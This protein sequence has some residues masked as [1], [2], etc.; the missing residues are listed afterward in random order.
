MKTRIIGLFFGVL[1]ATAP[2]LFALPGDIDSTFNANVSNGSVY[3][4]AAQT[5]G[6]IVI[7]GD[8]T[9]V[10]VQTRNRVARLNAD[11][12]LDTGFNPNANALV[13]CVAIQPDGKIVIG[14]QF[15]Q[16]GGLTRGNI[17]RLNADGTV[18]GTG[19]FNPG[20]GAGAEV[21]NVLIQPDGKI[22]ITG[23]FTTVNSL[24]RSSIA[25]LNA[26]GTVEDTGTFNIGTGANN[27]IYGSALQAD[28]KILI[29]GH[30][31]TF[32]G[33]TRTRIARLNS[34]GTLE[35]TGTFNPGT[36][37]NSPAYAIAQQPDGKI[38][39]GG[40]FTTVNGAAISR[41]VRLNADGTTA[42]AITGSPATVRCLALQTDGKLLVG[43]DFNALNGQA[44][45]RIA[46]LNADGTLEATGTFSTGAGA[47]NVVRGL[48]LLPDGK[49]IVSGGYTTFAG[50][51]TRPRITRLAND[52]A[53][54]TLTIPTVSLAQWT[55][56]GAGPEIIRATFELS[57]DGGTNWSALGT[58]IGT[59]TANGWDMTGLSLS[60]GGL[61][62]ARGR[63][64]GGNQTGS[65]SF[66]ETVQ[67]FNTSGPEIGLEQ[68]VNT[69]LTDGSST[70]SFGTGMTATT[71]AAK[72]FTIRNLGFVALTGVSVTRDG[73]ASSE[74]TIDTTG[75]S[76]TVAVGASTTFSVT[77]TP[78]VIGARTAMLH[79]ASDDGDENPFDIAL[80]GNGM[81]A[82]QIAQQAYA[83]ASNTGTGDV[84]GV[85]VAISGDTVV[86]G[87][88]SE[89]SSTTGIN[90]TPNESAADSG[91]VY[92]F[93]RSGSTW[94][95]QAYLKAS[96]TGAG[97]QFGVAVAIAGDTLVVGAL[98]EDGSST[99][100]NGASNEGAADSGAAYVFVRSGTT[101]TQQAY[102]KAS[103]TG[104][105]DR[106]G[107]AV[108]ISGD[109][110]VVGAYL[111]DSSATGINGNQGDNSVADCGAAYVFTR[112]GITW[113]QQAYLKGSSA[114]ISDQFGISVGISGDTVVVGDYGDDSNATGINGNAADNSSMDSGA[115][116]VFVRSG[117]TWTQQA[118]L[119]ASNTRAGDLFGYFSAIDGNT[120]V[121]SSIREDSAATGING[122]QSDSNAADAG[123][124]YV[125]TR[126]G[127]TW[128][129]QAYLKASNTGAGDNFG[130]SVAISGDTI[131]IGANLED[132]AASGVYG[133]ESD[134]SATD[135]GAAYVFVRA[136]STWL[137]QG[138]LKPSN[139][140]AGDGFGYY[141]ALAGGT[142]VV[143]AL[144]ED[145]NATGI[146]GTQTDNSLA[147][148]GAAYIF[149]GLGPADITVEQPVGTVL[150]DAV[151]S[152]AFG[153]VS[154]PTTSAAKTFT[155]TNAGIGPMLGISVLKDGTHAAEFSLNTTGMTTSLP[156]GASTTFAVNFAP[157]AAG[158]RTAALHIYCN[159]GDESPFDIALTGTGVAAPEIVVEQPVG[160]SLVDGSASIN[161]NSVALTYSST[162]KTFS[163]SNTGNMALDVTGITVAGS[164]PGDFAV[165]SFTAGSVV[166][167]ASMTFTVTFTPTAI[168]SR[169]AVVSIASDDADEGSFD[170]NV[171][172]SGVAVAGPEIA[173]EQP[174]GT[175]LPLN[176]TSWGYNA[177]SLTTLPPGLVGQVAAISG[178]HEHNV[179]LKI[180]GTVA[181]WGD[182]FYGQCNVPAGLSNVQAVAGGGYHSLALKNDGTVVAWGYGDLGQ[183]SVPGGLTNVKA[184]AG[185]NFHSLA[186]KTDGTV[187]AWGLNQYG[188]IDV[189]V[190]LNGVKAIDGG[191]YH[192]LALKTDGTVVAWGYHV[193]TQPDVP[194]GLSGVTAISAGVAFNYAL[195]NDGTLIGWGDNSWGQLDAPVGL[196]NVK[197]VV[198]GAL[199]SAVLNTDGTVLAWGYND[200]GQTNVP[201]GLAG[202]QTF[203]A[204]GH[205]LVTLSHNIGFGNV[206]ISTPSA[207]KVFTIRNTGT[208][209]LNISGV[210]VSGGSASDFSVN[211][212]GMSASVPA[213][214]STTFSVVFTPGAA[215]P[216][217]TSLRVLSDDADEGILNLGLSGNG[218]TTNANLSNLTLSQGT[219]SPL[220]A[221]GTTSYTAGVFNYVGSITVTPTVADAGATVT[222]NGNAVASGNTSGPINLVEGNN[223]INVVVTASDGSTTKTYTTTVTRYA[224]GNPNLVSITMS[225]G[226]YAPIFW[227]D[228]LNY[229]ALVPNTTTSLTVT[230]S[231]ADPSSAITVNG[232]S[233]DTNTP[234]QAI[235]LTVGTTAIAIQ[236]NAVGGATKTFT[237]YVTRAAA[238]GA[239]G[240]GSLDSSF[241]LN[242]NGAVLRSSTL[243][244]DGK[245]IVCGLFSSLGGQPRNSIARLNPD[246]SL[247]STA[248]FNPGTGPNNV[249]ISAT[250]QDD[251]KIIVA[252]YFTFWNNL[253]RNYIAR[254][255]PDG[256]L[257]STATFNTG[258][259][260]NGHVYGSWVQPDGK[261]LVWG[262]F[263]TFNGQSRKG[264]ARL[265]SDGSLE[266]TSTFNIGTGANQEIIGAALQPDGK[267]L[268][269]GLF[270]QFNGQ[271]RTHIA[272]L[273]SNGSLESLA[274]FNP[275]TGLNGFAPYGSRLFSIVP[276]PDGKILLS[277]EF[278]LADGQPRSQIAR[279]NANG[280]LDS[281][282]DP[283]TGAEG[284]EVRSMALQADGKVLIG[285]AFH[286]VN[287]EF[288]NGVARLLANGAVEGTATFNLGAGPSSPGTLVHAIA[289]QTDGRLWMIGGFTDVNGTPRLSIA[290]LLNGPATQVVNVTSSARAE[291]LRGGT[292]P[293]VS[294]VTFEK[295]MDGG[296]T[297]LMLGTG[298]RIAGGWEITG[299]SLPANGYSVRARGRVSS[300][301]LNGSS[302]LVESIVIVPTLVTDFR[303]TYFNTTSNTGIAANT[304]DPDND[305]L[306]NIVEYAFG[307][308]PVQPGASSQLP[309]PV[310]NGDNFGFSFVQPPNVAGIVYGA[311][312]S[313]NMVDWFPVPAQ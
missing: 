196:N 86:V 143:G 162:P 99:G 48:T 246:G 212:S 26:N 198:T 22:I 169:N 219:L 72:V 253:A 60:G 94:T 245:I 42:T 125:Y 102:L 194:V 68:P 44:R 248:T 236:V 173:I 231:A 9:T 58:G 188:Q 164:H 106:F 56:T 202:V 151:G 65:S 269:G 271:P 297:W 190:G 21:D 266:S 178:G 230:P 53:A 158:V 160:T 310:Q 71:S 155:I 49:I 23:F 274:T 240:P 242:A 108:T 195:K 293:E 30:F 239:P 285:G 57:T 79:I 156:P 280:S 142:A 87:A 227:Y 134:N 8:F 85:S 32:N 283:G 268:V 262:P 52:S 208:T 144:N 36:G 6:R 91:A 215:G 152:I 294:Q 24:S 37:L 255:N 304:A 101:W 290:R 29:S 288:R 272:R 119:K 130:R 14:G 80:T 222:V 77:F 124:A 234:S 118:Y 128:T 181:A 31:T 123:A 192:S 10:G 207:A 140:D 237:L 139:L 205:H 161:Y 298:A 247:E 132:S 201:A 33:T 220:F 170:I 47:D 20:T 225:T 213:A 133:N 27:S 115:A 16:V 114:S 165:G 84:F 287:E 189:P 284:G 186:L 204:G 111:E 104:G 252:G 90:S 45:G 39:L 303:Q 279:I 221:P 167:N 34:D 150:T 127:T 43:G 157:A 141:V 105:N 18:E 82:S 176:F 17:A 233:V 3:A 166:P 66:V 69:N 224:P 153:N 251:G 46:R 301:D 13:T 185:G 265:N 109:T 112:S 258:S 121:I 73:A 200:Y 263:T 256:T 191:F 74:Y 15:S 309:Q 306:E 1:I 120:I 2:R 286:T 299:Q 243:Q 206:V 235:A 244:P 97:D 307:L 199:H 295:S 19:T 100:V 180:D 135:A 282:F 93:V 5:D 214:G 81:V 277:G 59:R 147:S 154:V 211:T 55:R 103:N 64:Y 96:N 54:T 41:L 187:V 232:Q 264:I 149:T 291:W 172:G 218:S 254:L 98:L 193:E 226:G 260:S 131:L 312:C 70:V 267:I 216:S 174:A 107:N 261:I 177:N 137:P 129:Q 259:G 95:Q 146:G 126:S 62:R 75:M 78:T 163:I 67:S 270:T 292:A 302:G 289:V 12:S 113:T 122:S 51:T 203:I 4:A 136:G 61:I 273:N 92:V 305:G 38:W 28:G 138:Y 35:G 50:S 83:K 145:S 300:G 296:A 179:V 116:F 171:S 89:D 184:I 249:V 308:N 257:E 182:N 250:V 229:T 175:P 311:K 217:Q 209:A 168:G 238:P 25:R 148:P 276:Q 223:V 278:I 40:D 210:S 228:T 197:T 183:T 7:V 63:V 159:D 313:V 110:I 275:G 88:L 241:T 11:G 281:T 76:S 117:T